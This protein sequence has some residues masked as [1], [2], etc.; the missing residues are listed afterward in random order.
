MYIYYIRVIFA[1]KGK[2]SYGYHMDIMWISYGTP[3]F[4][5]GILLLPACYPHIIR[6][7]TA[8]HIMPTIIGIEGQIPPFFIYKNRCYSCIYHFFV[9]SLQPNQTIY[10]LCVG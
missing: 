8:M 10:V 6:M 7:L 2:I 1:K 3:R 5:Y 9:V 4:R